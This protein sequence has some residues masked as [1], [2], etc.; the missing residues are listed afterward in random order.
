MINIYYMC[1]V[2]V[3]NIFHNNALNGHAIPFL[4]LYER[5]ETLP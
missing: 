4:S 3:I 2:A 1:K 5:Q